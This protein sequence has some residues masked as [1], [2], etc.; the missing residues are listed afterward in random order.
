MTEGLWMPYMLMFML[1]TL[2]QGH[3]G[4]AKAKN[5]HCVPSATKQA[6]SIKLATMV[7]HFLLDLDF[8][9]IHMACPPCC[10]LF[11]YNMFYFM[12]NTT[13]HPH[14]PPPAMYPVCIYWMCKFCLMSA[15]N[16]NYL[17]HSF[18]CHAT[19]LQQKCYL[20]WISP[21]FSK[22]PNSHL[23][24][25]KLKLPKRKKERNTQKTKTTTAATA[26]S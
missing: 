21:K 26:T 16:D 23:H 3:S 13:T 4:S 24:Y 25:I 15:L 10:V 12:C 19:M 17:F 11:Q 14:L 9:K 22:K 1:V 20:I 8:A 7:G 2:M 6:I 5:H 18:T